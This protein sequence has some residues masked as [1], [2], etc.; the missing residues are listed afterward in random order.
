MNNI[1]VNIKTLA[2]HSVKIGRLEMKQ[3][4]RDVLRD[5]AMREDNIHVL[6]FIRYLFDKIG[7]M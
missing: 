4:I 7:N 5:A 2:D 3:E 1:N 6:L